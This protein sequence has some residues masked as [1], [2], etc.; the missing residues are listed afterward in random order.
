MKNNALFL[1]NLVSASDNA[2]QFYERKPDAT[3]ISVGCADARSALFNPFCFTAASKLDALLD[4]VEVN[5][6][7]IWG[8]AG[9]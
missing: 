4:D 2:T 6:R 8:Q 9:E 1:L 7:E 5:E 3:G